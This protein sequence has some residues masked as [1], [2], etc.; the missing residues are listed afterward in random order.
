MPRILG[1][2]G[3]GMRFIN[4]VE[5]RTQ[6]WIH[7]TFLLVIIQLL[8]IR[9][10]K[11]HHWTKA[12]KSPRVQTKPYI[13]SNQPSAL[14]PRIQSLGSFFP[15]FFLSGPTTFA[16]AGGIKSA[17]QPRDWSSCTLTA[18]SLKRPLNEKYLSLSL[19][20]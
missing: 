3:K 8:L 17:H 12:E 6:N 4:D 16:S 19:K 13:N 11:K 18:F 20:N 9:T 1:D 2:I 15:S 14:T 7:R 10:W 5:W